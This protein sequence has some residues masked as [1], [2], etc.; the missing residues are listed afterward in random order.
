MSDSTKQILE[1][2][3][4]NSAGAYHETAFCRNL[5]LLNANEMARLKDATVAVAG[6]GGVGG[7]HLIAL[8]RTGI[9]RF[10]VADFDRFDPVNINRQYGAQV[11]DF[12]RE[13]LAA[14]VDNVRQVN[15]YLDI[16][17]YPEGITPD[18]VDD[19]LDGVDL[20]VDGLDF[21]VLDIRRMV[22]TRAVEL[23]IPVVTAGPMGFS[24]ALLVFAPGGM[25]F[26]Q[27]FDISDDD[28][29]MDK[30]IKFAAGLAPRPTHVRYI[31][32]DFVDLLEKRGPSLGA[33]CWLCSSLTATEAVRI[34]TGRKAVKKTPYYLQFDPYLRKLVKGRLWGGNRHPLQRAKIW[35]IKNYLLDRNTIV[36]PVKPEEPSAEA[37]F[38]TKTDYII[39]AGMQAPSG[40]NVQPWRFKQDDTGV[41]I[42]MESAADDSLFNVQQ[43]ATIVACGAAV[44]NMTIAAGACGLG[45]RVNWMPT[46]H[47]EHV[48]R[49]AFSPD[50]HAGESVLHDV[51]WRRVTNRKPY[52]TRAVEAGVW[53]RMQ[54][55]IE[56]CP[57]V[58]LQ[59]INDKQQLKDFSQAVFWA[60][61]I[62]TEHRGL[63]EHLMKMIRF[64][65][66]EAETTRD[67]LPLKNLEAGMAGEQFMKATRPW[68]VMSALNTVGVGR[69]VAMH[70]A[71]G[72]R[73]SGGVGFLSVD[74]T[75]TASLL[76]A[77]RALERIWLTF[78][79]NG[80]RFQPAA[81]PAL[82]RLRWLLEGPESFSDKHQHLLEKVWPVCDDLFPGFYGTNPVL[83]FRVGFGRGIKYGTYR[84]PLESFL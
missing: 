35:L 13:K 61:R 81:A 45:A 71:M 33:A 55:T 41:D 77:G 79:H 32:M 8:A 59:W 21:F 78:T 6:L 46:S 74:S 76:E 12:G 42:F 70:S 65:R 50:D 44:E 82:F 11:A 9:G 57:G 5:G 40:D 56:D 64:S 67:G 16:T 37:P 60:D 34:I 47:P 63:H 28:P 2:Y 18:N 15:P 75:D 51:I 10:K 17:T 84:R 58:S 49:L 72:I 38:K 36:G 14:M 69:M 48:A 43:A 26:D 1:A 73:K 52:S 31:D 23:G 24:S 66:T 68:K 3:S 53:Q 54:E 39:R 30:V 7:G 19:F 83:F 29:Y 25:T 22:F 4:L 27:Y 20:V 62:R 80:I